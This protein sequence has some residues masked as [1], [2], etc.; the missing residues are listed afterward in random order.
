MIVKIE[1]ELLDE[2]A[3]IAAE[4]RKREKKREKKQEKSKGIQIAEGSK[5]AVETKDEGGRRGSISLVEERRPRNV[6]WF[7]LAIF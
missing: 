7:Y 3:S 6:S 4:V 5:K 2:E 1:R